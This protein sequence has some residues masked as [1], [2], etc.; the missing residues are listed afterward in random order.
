[1][2]DSGFVGHWSGGYLTSNVVLEANGKP[3]GARYALLQGRHSRVLA[4]GFLYNFVN[5][6]KMT[7]V[8]RVQDVIQQEWFRSALVEEHFDAI[9]VLAHMDCVDPLVFAILESIRS[10][11]GCE[12]PIQFLTGHSHRRCFEA[13]DPASS[14]MEA[15][16]FLDTVGFV[17]FPTKR[18]Y[19]SAFPNNSRTELFQHA[20]I[21]ASRQGL[22][23]ALGFKDADDMSTGEGSGLTSI[24]RSSQRELHLSTRLGCSPTTF[25]LEAS[26]NDPTSLWGLYLNHV[27]PSELFKFNASKLFLQRTGAFRY[28][29]FEGEITENDIIAVCPFDD[30]I[31]AVADGIQ[32]AIVLEMLQRLSSSFDS[33]MPSLPALAFSPSIIELDAYYIIYVPVWNMPEILDGISNVTGKSYTP[34]KLEGVSTTNLW[35]DFVSHSW[36]TCKD[37]TEYGYVMPLRGQAIAE[38]VQVRF[39]AFLSAAAGVA[40]IVLLVAR[41]LTAGTVATR[42]IESQSRLLARFE[43]QYGSI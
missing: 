18:T 41:V 9:L 32:G 10:I 37:A 13:T 2:L 16:R 14:S 24:I 38:E 4:F 1:L 43:R 15:G 17:S 30:A 3:V 33:N 5:N 21:Q 31:Y 19:A 23:Q 34:V 8:E 39:P 6:C 29:L 26:L 40:F 20:F 36:P 35:R 22:S 11:V 28:A 7:I 27:I 25:N 42:T 12:M